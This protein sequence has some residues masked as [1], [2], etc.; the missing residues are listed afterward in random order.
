MT[1][2]LFNLVA[3]GALGS[4]FIPTFTGLL[5]H[6]QTQRAWKLASAVAN[7]LLLVLSA[8]GLLAAVF[9]PQI[10]RYGLYVLSPGR[11]QPGQEALTVRL[12]RIMLPTVVIFGLSGLVMGILNAHQKLLAAGHRPGD[13][14]ARANRRGAAPPRGVGHSTPGWW[15]ADRRAAAPARPAA[16]PAALARALL[17]SRLGLRLAEVREVIV[18]M[19]P[20][21]LGVAVVQINFLVNTIIALSMPEGSVSADLAGLHVMLM[22][23]VAM[24]QS[25]AV[26]AMPTF[27]AQAALGKLDELR[28]TLAGS[29]RGVILLGHARLAGL[30]P[31]A[32]AAHSPPVRKRTTFTA[33]S[34]RDGG[35]GAAVV[36]R[37]AGGPLAAGGDRARFLCP[38][39]Y[40][41][42]GGGGGGGDGA[43]RGFQLCLL[44]LFTRLGWMPHGGLA[45]ANSLATFLEM[46]VLLFLLRRRLDGLGGGRVL[47]A[48][49]Q[50]GLGGLAMAAGL[51]AWLSLGARLPDWLLAAGGAGLGMLLYT[52]G[53]AILRVPELG[54]L[55]KYSK[56]FTAVKWLIMKGLWCMVRR[57]C[58]IY[59]KIRFKEL[60]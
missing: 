43:Q 60:L 59:I 39:G 30:D 25:M 53:M 34:T 57:T 4:A 1:E 47:S 31:A 16:G 23:Q 52:A 33:R 20:R 42:A 2:L 19:G 10:V 6:D 45:L 58:T 56:R 32:H 26:A 7:L 8:V 24:A 28:A 22:P 5:A 41:H 17:R 12:L 27:S 14:F 18:L 37:R 51:W 40:A 29:L 15:R 35:L 44:R 49:G 55:W 36:R 3:G 50:A 21:V 11:D 54:V 9:A 46:G 48:L 38:E 13:V